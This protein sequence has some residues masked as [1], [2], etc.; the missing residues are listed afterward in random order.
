MRSFEVYVW[1]NTCNEKD[2]GALQTSVTQRNS[3]EFIRKQDFL[4]VFQAY[5]VYFQYSWFQW[6]LTNETAVLITDFTYTSTFIFKEV[7]L[8]HHLLPK[9]YIQFS[10][11]LY[12]PHAPCTSSS[13][14]RTPKQY[15]ISST[16][17]EARH[18]KL[19]SR[20]PLQNITLS[21]LLS[22]TLSLHISTS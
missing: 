10:S 5:R 6:L 11:S 22:N 18:Y 21:T 9:P 17:N 1:P 2:M 20:P 8:L 14:I 13:F 16:G 4:L 7:S 12:V 19:F 3:S 15:L